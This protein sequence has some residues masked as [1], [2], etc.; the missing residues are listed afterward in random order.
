MSAQPSAQ[1][2]ALCDDVDAAVMLTGQTVTIGRAEH[3]TIVVPRLLASRLH[4]RI[5]PQDDRYVLK[6]AGSINGTYING[7]RVGTPQM[8]RHGDKI[9]IAGPDPLLSFTDPDSTR[10][11]PDALRFDLDQQLFFL[12]DRTLQLSQS[13]FKLLLHLRAHHGRVCSRESCVYA[14]WHT[15]NGVESYRAALDQFVYQIRTKLLQIDARADLIKTIRGEGYLL[16][17]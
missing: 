15:R 14:V 13:E 5:E 16:E 11:R 12:H 17:L 6:D 8:L 10:G 7:Q 2:V 3:C 1:L 9:G 4:A